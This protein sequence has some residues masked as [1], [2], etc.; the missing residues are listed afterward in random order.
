MAYPQ[1]PDPYAFYAQPGWM[2]PGTAP[3]AGAGESTANKQTN[4]QS[5]MMMMLLL[6]LLPTVWDLKELWTDASLMCCVRADSQI[7][8][9]TFPGLP[10]RSVAAACEIKAYM[11]LLLLLLY[12]FG[13]RRRRRVVLSM[14][15][16]CG[17]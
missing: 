2:P 9:G 7:K 16:C 4:K 11:L 10:V 1:Y 12:V 13:R 3:P 8:F 6:L 5:M 15:C 14:F 17:G